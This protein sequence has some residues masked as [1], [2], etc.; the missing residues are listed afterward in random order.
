[1]C[2]VARILGEKKMDAFMKGAPEVVAGLCKP[3]TGK[4]RPL[5]APAPLPHLP[6]GRVAGVL[7]P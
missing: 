1:M 5:L 2:V 4:P 3:A 6:E 7:L